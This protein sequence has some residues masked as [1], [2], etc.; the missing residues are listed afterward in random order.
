MSNTFKLKD[1][2]F[3]YF[4]YSGNI[5]DFINKLSETNDFEIKEILIF[6]GNDSFKASLKE[7]NFLKIDNLDKVIINGF[8]KG[9]IIDICVTETEVCVLGEKKKKTN[10]F[11][12][13]IV[14]F[15]D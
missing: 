6:C 5:R 13:K 9:K 12:K 4:D 8:Y 14:D 3:G 11:M 2:H 15:S 10:S 7:F 1:R